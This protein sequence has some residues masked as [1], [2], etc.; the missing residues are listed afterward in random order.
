MYHPRD[1][2][3]HWRHIIRAIAAS[4][5]VTLL[6][7]GCSPPAAVSPQGSGTSP[8]PG[9]PAGASHEMRGEHEGHGDHGAPAAPSE[10][11]L[12]TMPAMPAAGQVTDLSLQILGP[13]QKPVTKFDIL[14][15][16]L[17]HLI[18]VR[19][20]LD[21]FAHLHPE[22]G[23]DGTLRIKHDFGKAG[24]Y[25]LFVDYQPGGGAPSLAMGQLAVA[26]DDSPAAALVPNAGT[27][28]ADGDVEAK[29]EVTPEAEGTT[30]RF[31]ITG[32]GGKAIDDLQPY[33]GAMGHLVVIKSGSLDYVHA[34][35]VGDSMTAPDGVVAFEAHLTSA[36]IYKAWGQFRH[37]ERIL[38]FPVVLQIDAG[39][40]VSGGHKH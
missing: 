33:L 24:P 40:A 1:L 39:K 28:I 10:L 11:K 37:K 19:E 20:G 34:H 30:I 12:V 6:A 9:T 18:I 26:G 32:R 3:F 7:A 29:V 25:R 31:K 17:A 15:E 27:P 38:T 14:H 5:A 21:E 35:P 2:Q 13:D 4:G 36:G 8:A 16:K 22:V 23:S